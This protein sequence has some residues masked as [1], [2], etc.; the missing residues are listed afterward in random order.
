MT[1]PVQRERL[2]WARGGT[3][4]D[5]T[6]HAAGRNQPDATAVGCGAAPSPA[7]DIVHTSSSEGQVEQIWRMAPDGSNPQPITPARQGIT[8]SF[9]V[10]SPDGRTMAFMPNR[11][12]SPGRIAIFAMHA[13]GLAMRRLTNNRV[14]DLHPNW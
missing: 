11:G 5:R 8:E 6:C 14:R 1:P 4:D 9:A 12:P 10:W 13:D 7:R 3:S 2:L